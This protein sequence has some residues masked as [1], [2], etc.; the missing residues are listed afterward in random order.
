LEGVGIDCVV[1]E[2][3]HT[4]TTEG[5]SRKSPPPASLEF[6]FFEHKST[7]PPTPLEFPQVLC[8]PPIPSEKIV[9]ARK[10]VE[11]K[12]NTPNTSLSALHI[13]AV[14]ARSIVT[15]EDQHKEKIQQFI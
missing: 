6:P 9:L 14:Y 8:R 15:S 2:N 11:V 5:I 1:P 10:C 7:P 13:T 12:V 3:I 4:P